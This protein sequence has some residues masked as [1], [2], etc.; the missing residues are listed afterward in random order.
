MPS[1]KERTKKNHQRE[2]NIDKKEKT[3]WGTSRNG[4]TLE[5]ST[6]GVKGLK[7]LHRESMRIN[8]QWLYLKPLWGFT[9]ML[10]FKENIIAS[11]LQ[12]KTPILEKTNAVSKN[13]VDK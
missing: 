4:W 11:Y 9:C 12:I 10:M 2:R 13:R 1:W 6:V 8:M 5:I 3:S 7:Y